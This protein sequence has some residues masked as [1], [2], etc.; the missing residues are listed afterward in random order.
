MAERNVS[1]VI[2]GVTL[3]GTY[4]VKDGIVTVRTPLGSKIQSGWQT[5]ETGVGGLHP[6]E[7]AIL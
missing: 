7:R 6:L 4:S 2:N 1:R 3:R 5:L